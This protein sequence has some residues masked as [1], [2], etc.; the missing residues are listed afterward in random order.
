M[1]F[2]QPPTEMNSQNDSLMEFHP[3]REKRSEA[4]IFENKYK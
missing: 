1:E 4:M 2:K 3:P